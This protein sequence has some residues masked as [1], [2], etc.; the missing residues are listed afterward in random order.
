MAAELGIIVTCATH[1][2]SRQINEDSFLT[3]VG[4]AA[5][6]GTLGLLAVADGM[7][8]IRGTGA[9]ASALAIKTVADAFSGGCAVASITMSEIPNLLRFA[10]QKANAAVFR[11]QAEDKSL[12]GMGTTC[13]AAALTADAVSIV[14]V[15]DSRA[16]LLRGD[17]LVRL[18]MDEW[19]KQ[20]GGLTVVNRAIGW[21]PLLPTE[22][23]SFAI[24]EGDRILLCTDGL[25]D[26]M[27][28]ES[29]RE[30]LCSVSEVSA[31]SALAISAGVQSGSDNVTIIAA[32]VVSK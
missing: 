23:H 2:G 16:Y 25:T 9:T 30:A 10:V 14:S 1:K 3:L 28:D 12:G 13:V 4:D 22:P 6:C 18:T 8:G 24:C 29:I 15:G 31:C 17:E 32:R 21:Q 26:A 7:G 20:P 11:A 19:V 5:P 27:P